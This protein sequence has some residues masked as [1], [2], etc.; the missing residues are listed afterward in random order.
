MPSPASTN[1]GTPGAPL[2]AFAM[3]YDAVGN[4]TSRSDKVASQTV[5]TTDYVYDD[6]D[7]VT[8]ISRSGPQA[9]TQ[10]V[11]LQYDAAGLSGSVLARGKDG[12][13]GTRVVDL[14]LAEQLPRIC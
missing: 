12:I 5:G 7:W 14:P 13:G 3:T 11:E 6:R 9:S 2:V 10:R 4:R 8:R 1:A